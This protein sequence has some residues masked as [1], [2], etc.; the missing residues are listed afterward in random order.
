MTATTSLSLNGLCLFVFLGVYPSEQKR[1]RSVTM[2]LRV[3]FPAPPLGCESDQLKDTYCYAD[4]VEYLK[5][6][7]GDRKFQL[8]EYL[9][10]EVH[11]LLKDYFPPETHVGVRVTKHPCLAEL[12]RGAT[13][14]YSDEKISWSS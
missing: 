6:K 14:E 7:I 10:K 1:M 2:D 9:S 4:M 3:K 11:R 13:F 5:D 8:I 12:S